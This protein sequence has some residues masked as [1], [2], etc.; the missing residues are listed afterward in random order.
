MGEFGGGGF[1][2]NNN[3]INS[4]GGPF[5]GGLHEG[6]VLLLGKAARE[7]EFHIIQELL[8]KSHSNVANSGRSEAYK[9]LLAGLNEERQKTCSTMR[10]VFNR[11]FGATFLTD[12][13][14]ESA[15]AYNIHQYA[16]V[17]TSKAGQRTLCSIHPRRGFMYHLT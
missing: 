3:T 13:S 16:D 5:G 4:H 10:T 8:G 7:A 15:F 17:Y 14:Q 12:T 9:S 1:E 11:S 2:G 6:V